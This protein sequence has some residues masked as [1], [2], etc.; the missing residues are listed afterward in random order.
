MVLI[1]ELG[2]DELQPPSC[3]TKPTTPVERRPQQRAPDTTSKTEQ[4]RSQAAPEKK[5]QPQKTTVQTSNEAEVLNGLEAVNDSETSRWR[6]AF[7]AVLSQILKEYEGQDA[8]V[9]NGMET[10]MRKLFENPYH[11]ELSG[12]GKT[13]KKDILT[14]EEAQ[15]VIFFPRL[16]DMHRYVA[17]FSL[18]TPTAT[19]RRKQLMKFK[20]MS[21]LYT[22]HR[23]DGS[24]MDRFMHC[25][26]L[27]SLTKLLG[28]DHVV[29]QSQA[30]EL[31]MELLSPLMVLSS[32]T[33]SLRQ[34][35]LH[36][37]VFVCLRSGDL[38]KNFAK[39]I[40]EPHELFPRSHAHSVKI[41]LGAIGWL[42]PEPGEISEVGLPDGMH[43]TVESLKRFLEA[44]VTT[45][46]V[47]GLAEDLL[48]E[49]QDSPAIRA[50]PLRGKRVDDA[51]KDI[52]APAAVAR[53]DAA[54]AWQSL[55]RLGNEAYGAGLIWPAEAAYRLALNDGAG[56]VPAE[57]A[58][59]IH[60]NH[61][62]VLLRAGQPSDAVAASTKAL[63]LNPCNAKAAYRQ[64]QALLEQTQAACGQNAVDFVLRAVEAAELAAR[65]SPNDAKVAELLRKVHEC[66]E[67][68]GATAPCLQQNTGQDMASLDAMD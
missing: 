11:E 13:D 62:L 45:P 3:P 4:E 50:D 33:S 56:T 29:I 51:H 59:L 38:W 66:K 43:D 57:E 55:R 61:A 37:Q 28:E 40:A 10:G 65:L 18:D 58:S 5:E 60:S 49:L 48:R 53:E 1:E 23:K 54:H 19:A 30:V 16:S 41:L 26:G 63:E 31:L 17:A 8:T 42:H 12:I 2:P 52:F 25:G 34:A 39:I 46:D 27:A 44:G 64:A 14:V 67:A 24:L 68:I 6:Q 36:H 9:R 21:V 7:E 22:L 20:L 32:A 47:R 35:H 15:R